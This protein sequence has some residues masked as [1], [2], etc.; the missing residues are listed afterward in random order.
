MITAKLGQMNVHRAGRLLV[1]SI[2]LIGLLIGLFYAAGCHIILVNVI[3]QMGMLPDVASPYWKFMFPLS[4]SLN[5]NMT[6]IA[7]M[8]EID[9]YHE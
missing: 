1:L 4:S 7:D 2:S 9:G 5:P 8:P 6:F 3:N